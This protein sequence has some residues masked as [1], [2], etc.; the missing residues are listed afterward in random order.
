MSPVAWLPKIRTIQQD[1]AEEAA[2]IEA[3]KTKEI[4]TSAWMPQEQP[5]TMPEARIFTEVPTYT[6]PVTQFETSR[7]TPSEMKPSPSPT[8]A[9]RLEPT[10][11]TK[12]EWWEKPKVWG[13]AAMEKVGETISKVPVLPKA[14]EAVAPVFEF[15]HERLEKPWASIITAPWSPSLAWESGESWLEHEKREYVAWKAPTYVKGLTEFSMPLWWMP[16][17]TWI[18]GAKAMATGSKLVR[19]MKIGEALKLPAKEVL[20]ATYKQDWFRG[21]AHW[22]ENKP[23]IGQVVNLVGGE[24]AFARNVGEVFPAMDIATRRLVVVNKAGVRVP[25]TDVVRREIV[26]RAVLQDM[27]HGYKGLQ[28]PRMQALAP[29]GDMVKALQIDDFGRVMTA[30]PKEGNALGRGLTDVFE[31]PDLYT[32]TT[33]QAEAIVKE[34]RKILDE[35]VALAAE[36]GVKVPKVP[37]LHRLVEGKEVTIGDRTIYEASEYG[38]RFEMARHYKTMEEGITAGVRYSRDPLKGIASTIDHYFK[39][40]ATKR[41][42]DEV[43]KLGK[44]IPEMVSLV[45][46][47]L[48]EKMAQLGTQAGAASYLT[49][50]LKTLK[51]YLGDSIPG[52]V[53]SKIRRGM[54]EA[55]ERIEQA[56][57]IAPQEAQKIM[58]TLAK[59]IS[60][61]TKINARSLKIM[62]GQF[63][64]QPGKI[65]AREIDDL[66]R[67][68]NLT[69]DTANRAIRQGY[70]AVYQSRKQ[71]VNDTLKAVRNEAD[72]L[73]KTTKAEL[74]PLKAQYNRLALSYREATGQIF[75][76]LAK[77]QRHPAFRNR[78]FDAEVVKMAE[79]QMGKQGNK[80]VRDMAQVSAVGRLAVA[81][82]D[83]S[84]PFIQGLAVL[85]RNPVAWAKGVAQQFRFFVKPDDF[86]QYMIQPKVRALAAERWMHG[87]SRSSFEFFEALGP[88]QRRA[89]AIPKVGAK[90]TRGIQETYGRA[91]VAFS[92]FGEATRNYMWEA[93]R[94]KA[95]QPNGALDA[96]I[97]RELARSIDRMTGVMSMEALGMSRGQIDFEG[98]WLFFAPRYTRA[99]M[100]YVAD[101][102]KGGIAGA[103]ARKGLGALSAAGMTYYYGITTA[104]GQQPNLDI[105]SPRFMTVKIGDDYVGVGG[106]LYSL[107]RFGANVT[108]VMM[109]AAKEMFDGDM[110]KAGKELSVMSPLNFSRFD[111]PF[112]KFMFSRS[113]VLT[114]L[115]FGAA[116]EQ[117]NYF[118]EPLEDIASWGK[119][120]AEKVLPIAMQRAILEPEHRNPA[121]FI[122]EL[123]GMRTFPKG[124]WELQE[125][126][127]DRLAQSEHG[128]PY[129]QLD[130][131]QKRQID[132]HPDVIKF[133]EEID[134]MTTRRGKA[135]S[136]AFLER[137][138]DLDDAR[139]LHKEAVENLQKAYE[140]GMITGF[141][142]KEGVK[143]ANVGYGAT[144]EH[145]NKNPRYADVMEKLEEPREVNREYRWEL[146][147]DE[148]MEA[149]TRFEDEFGIFKFDAYNEFLEQLRRKYGEADFNRAREMQQE[150]YAEYPSL[151]QELAR[152]KKLLRPYWQVKE[153]AI[154]IFGEPTTDWARRRLEAFVSRIRKRLRASNPEV[155]KAYIKFYTD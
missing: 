123:V 57:T 96:A 142:F 5:P 27:R 113:S 120:M 81:A 55:M 74:A 11:T 144:Y 44:T 60:K 121:V 38:A 20:N 133:Q 137:S 127:K 132:R 86:F 153:E 151:F 70:K 19:G 94:V 34:G 109:N 140:A 91:E 139:F 12:I 36:E 141:E 112:Y 131:I 85:G 122:S 50:T 17:F 28:L 58:V 80:W 33:K 119:F 32:Y 128:L 75:G 8:V 18:K 125:E 65:L 111:N 154:K 1:I 126:E 148:L 107:A 23:I 61:E 54:P 49:K 71:F 72:E 101:M 104:L 59:T 25:V 3:L 90:I 52:G 31:N 79:A 117:K 129:D 118:G 110:E 143:D 39:R 134:K 98:A 95:L 51:S 46:P 150:K 82:L 146:A 48:I 93:L 102:M 84:A 83:F 35:V 99:G 152:A 41:F 40:I 21:L 37:F 135:L 73:L 64:R 105:S 138:R 15:I 69:N 56:F 47:E 10:V 114:G 97:A 136:V 130:L 76:G 78:I 77:F 145:I 149:T 43:G 67:S 9:P 108:G 124:A 24:A 68:L 155:E 16:W 100:S 13:E 4:R 62:V 103:E 22:A 147:Y 63:N 30:T 2:R 116:I 66:V 106:I 88:I 14:L 42:D 26:N 7:W 115:T 87:G 29:R 89:E 92:G 45:E 6:E 53:R